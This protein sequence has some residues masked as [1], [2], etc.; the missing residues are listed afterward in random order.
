[1]RIKFCIPN[2]WNNYLFQILKGIDSEDYLWKIGDEQEVLGH[3]A[4][5]F[6]TKY[7]YNGK[8]FY[9]KIQNQHYPIFADIRLYKVGGDTKFK[10]S[11]YK[12]F[13]K[14]D[15]LL[16]LFITDVE[17]VDIYCKDDNLVKIIY[18]HAVENQFTNIE[19]IDS[20]ENVRK[21]FSPYYD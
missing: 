9:Y 21:R 1:M 12:D 19:L 16:I 7:F 4:D 8:N 13:L 2:A 20:D 6:F 18:N 3:S 17:F 14:S 10:I 15:C 5:P 11:N